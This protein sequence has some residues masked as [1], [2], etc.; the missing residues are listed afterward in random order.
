MFISRKLG[1]HLLARDEIGFG[2]ILVHAIVD[3]AAAALLLVALAFVIAWL[4]EG[5][6][7]IAGP[8]PALLP[9]GPMLE[10]IATAGIADRLWAGG[11]VFST[12]VPTA[13]H[14]AILCMGVRVL[15]PFVRW[16]ARAVVILQ[17]DQP[18]PPHELTAVARYLVLRWVPSA[19]AGVAIVIAL[20]AL[21][22]AVVGQLARHLV[23]IAECGIELARWMVGPIARFLLSRDIELA[24]WMF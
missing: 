15:E 11:M 21:Y 23:S 4:I 2:I 3:L 1:R 14:L 8:G 7:E 9:L 19:V 17:K 6:N 10:K 12:L 16:R 5:F 20:V 22:L 24:N 13:A 18:P